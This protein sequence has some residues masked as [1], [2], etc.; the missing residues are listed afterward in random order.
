MHILFFFFLVVYT[1][2][3]I[4]II[5]TTDRPR[6]GMTSPITVPMI[7]EVEDVASCVCVCV[8]VWVCVCGWMG[9][10]VIHT[11]NMFIFSAD[12]I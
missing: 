11:Q 5:A 6:I 2:S 1:S 12:I 3:I 10:W 8:G 4:S 7:A 9:G